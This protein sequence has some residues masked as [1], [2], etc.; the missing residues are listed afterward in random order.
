MPPRWDPP[1][2]R[3]PVQNPP[4][5][6]PHNTPGGQK[7]CQYWHSHLPTSHQTIPKQRN[8]NSLSNGRN[9][10][11]L[12]GHLKNI[13]NAYMTSNDKSQDN[14]FQMA[15]TFFRPIYSLSHR[16]I[17][18]HRSNNYCSCSQFQ[19]FL[20][21]ASAEWSSQVD[22]PQILRSNVQI[23]LPTTDFNFKIIRFIA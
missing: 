21:P 1:A 2:M 5:K 12:F 18:S 8:C 3:L 15:K 23:Y 20:A 11:L 16:H 14:V 6:R 19:S 10:L 9:R 7:S 4:Q 13:T 22:D 17:T